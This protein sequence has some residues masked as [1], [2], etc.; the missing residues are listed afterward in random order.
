MHTLLNEGSFAQ[1]CDATMMKKGK[2]F[3]TKKNR[4]FKTLNFALHKLAFCFVTIIFVIKH[5]YFTC[6][7][8]IRQIKEKWHKLKPIR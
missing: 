5:F 8:L 3:V 6:V 2:M 7:L 1:V 4:R